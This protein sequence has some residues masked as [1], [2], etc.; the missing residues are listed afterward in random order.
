LE[1]IDFR[2]N[3]LTN[4]VTERVEEVTLLSSMATTQPQAAYIAFVVGYTFFFL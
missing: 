3:Y 1:G 4:K 2:K